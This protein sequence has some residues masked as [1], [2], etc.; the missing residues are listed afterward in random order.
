MN[1]CFFIIEKCTRH[2]ALVGK[3]DVGV[4]GTDVSEEKVFTLSV[5]L[6]LRV[7][8]FPLAGR[9][10]EKVFQCLLPLIMGGAADSAAGLA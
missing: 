6:A 7:V 9:G 2:L 8:C 3:G 10:R 5:K 4:V 1:N